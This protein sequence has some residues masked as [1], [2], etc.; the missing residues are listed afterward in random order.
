MKDKGRLL[1]L[2]TLPRKDLEEL[3]NKLLRS[4]VVKA[5]EH[6]LFWREK[7]D[8]LGIKPQII[9]SV[10]DL[11]RAYTKGLKVTDEDL[12][13]NFHKLC[14]DYLEE[15]GYIILTT[16]GT[17]KNVWKQIPYTDDDIRRSNEQA[18]ILFNSIGIERNSRNLNSF[19]PPPNAS[20]FLC[21]AALEDIGASQ[22]PLMVEVPPEIEFVILKSYKPEFVWKIGTKALAL[23]NYLKEVGENGERLG[24]KKICIGGEPFSYE[25]KRKTE[26]L[27]SVEVVDVYASAELSVA[28]FECQIHEGMHVTEN[29]LIMSIH[30]A[31][32]LEESDEGRI[33]ATTLYKD[34]EKPG[35]I[36]INKE[37]GDLT[38]N[39]GRDCECGRTT[40]KIKPP[41]RIDDIFAIEAKKFYARAVEEVLS[42]DN[43]TGNYVVVKYTDKDTG[44]LKKL[45][46]RAEVKAFPKHKDLTGEVVNAFAR[47]N[48][49]T[50]EILNRMEREKKIEIVFKPQGQLYEGLAQHV[51]RGKP[52]RFIEVLF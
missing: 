4:T 8:F 48:P 5:Y 36:L 24:V 29:R 7:F 17:S 44:Q 41:I 13:F 37:M 47:S 34:E 30:D 28:G 21:M 43:F 50:Y 26:K 45:E 20:G 46:I 10:E 49:L 32:T 11:K 12:L 39:L 23:G 1:P 15:E 16:S 33:V 52:V 51:R 35:M 25:L 9:K 22:Y 31:E 14:T 3:Q 27:W 40:L 6:S 2:E 42:D 38:K 18:N 19:G